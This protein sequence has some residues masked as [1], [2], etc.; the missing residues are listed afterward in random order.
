VR[1]II[2]SVRL[3]DDRLSVADIAAAVPL[4]V[5]PGYTVRMWKYFTTALPATISSARYRREL[6]LKHRRRTEEAAERAAG[7]RERLRAIEELLSTSSP[8]DDDRQY[9]GYFE[10][11]FPEDVAGVRQHLRLKA[12]A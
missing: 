1:Q 3:E 7:R 10:E 8:S 12:T 9:L 11:H 6:E 5:P 4:A 2:R